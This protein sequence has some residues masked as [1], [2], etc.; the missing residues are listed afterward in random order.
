VKLV[1]VI[2]TL[3][4]SISAILPAAEDTAPAPAVSVPR[5]AFKHFNLPNGLEI[6]SLEDHTNPTVAVQVWY[7]VGSKDDPNGRSGFAHL[8]EH[9]MFKGNEHLKP[10][11]F[12]NLTENVGGQNNA[13]TAPDVTVY[14]EE[15]PSNYLEPILWAEA[16]RMSSLALNDANFASERDVVKEEY[17]QRILANPYGEF[18]LAIE[19]NSFAKHPYKRPGIG[20]IAE[21]D[22]SKLPEVR[23]FHG[24][25]YR[26]DNATLIVVGD[27]KSDQLEAWV[28]TYFG[29]VKKPSEKIPRVKVTEPQR[30]EDTRKV[31]NTQKAPLPA[32]AVTYLAPSIRSE[33][34]AALS[35]ADTILSG[36]E[37]S[38]LYES[39][40]YEQQ[41]A[42]RVS[43]DADLRQDLGLL[44][45]RLILAS[46]K[47]LA[48]AEK[49]LDAQIDKVLK[50]GI[51]EDELNKAKNQ[52]LT[53]KF[54]ELQTAHGKASAIGEA[55]VIYGNA[56][57]V[58]QELAEIQAVTADQ[59]KKVL[60]KYIV[61]K[62]RVVVEYVPAQPKTA[63]K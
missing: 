8:F 42:A 53:G 52:Y 43:F 37:S 29:E 31:I 22:A 60:S 24:T 25:F 18:S 34:N 23:A 9:M 59:I 28:K 15:V 6:Y 4:I 41:I 11:T 33:D 40:V 12:E 35:L 56:E 45:F 16:E 58:N 30:K 38:R 36:G 5:L 32:F 61:G 51:S 63:A 13:F 10:D 2:V 55:A 44:S 50:D 1:P 17:R 48:D 46:G 26:P 14:H 57:H 47:S 49:A 19:Q 7:H 54:R 3:L 62:K 39:L 20:N 27:F 21:L